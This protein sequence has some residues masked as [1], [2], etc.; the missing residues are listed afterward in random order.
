[1]SETARPAQ[2]KRKPRRLT[3]G[4]HTLDIWAGI[5]PLVLA[6]MAFVAAWHFDTLSG[7]GIFLRAL[8]VALALL[9]AV[10]FG[11]RVHVPNHR[12]YYGGL[13]LIFLA[14]V[15]FWAGGDLAGMRGFSFG[16]GTA[17]RLFACGLA[18]AAAGIT[19]SGLLTKGEPIG[20]YAVR[21]PLFVT[22][23]II[24]FSLLIRGFTFSFGDTLIKVPAFGLIIASFT[25][26]VVAAGASKETRWVEA[27]IM[28]AALTAFCWFVFVYMLGLPFQLW[29]RF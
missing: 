7:V 21:G 2:R 25:T 20:G 26:F 23:A 18:I 16:A 17:P 9:G 11:L 5:A 29:P 24:A 14:L 28:A 4:H 13:A 1:M 8:G 27:V 22:L 6:L 15:A 10:I 12:D 3:T 19:V